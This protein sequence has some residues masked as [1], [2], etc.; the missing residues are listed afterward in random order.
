MTPIAVS[1]R[2]ELQAALD[3]VDPLLEGRTIDVELARLQVLLDPTSFRAEVAALVESA[4]IVADPSDAI[5]VRVARRGGSARVDVVVDGDGD[6]PDD[7]V[8]SITVPLA[9]GAANAAPG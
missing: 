7:V 9:P 6:R 8:G 1:V 2:E 4:V 5:T 3:L